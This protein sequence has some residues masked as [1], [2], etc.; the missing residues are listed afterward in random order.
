MEKHRA[1]I[2]LLL[3]SMSPEAKYS[4]SLS[5]LLQREDNV[6]R[7][8]SQSAEIRRRVDMNLERE[9][10]QYYSQ[11]LKSHLNHWIEYSTKLK[12]NNLK[13]PFEDK[14]ES[15]IENEE[16]L[17]LE[18]LKLQADYHQNWLKYEL[19]NLEEAFDLQN[20]KIDTEYSLIE[21]TLSSKLGRLQGISNRN[22][23]ES[24]HSKWYHAEKQRRLIHTAPVLTPDSHRVNKKELSTYSYIEEVL[25]FSLCEIYR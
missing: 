18:N 13:L 4:T 10:L 7:S 19:F 20:H 8:G 24:S 12:R 22:H 16:D 6:L 11:T 21:R 1:D 23:C 17:E 2:E 14:N 25:L 15:N 3:D 9:T 5:A